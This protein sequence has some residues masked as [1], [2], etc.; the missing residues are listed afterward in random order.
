MAAAVYSVIALHRAQGLSSVAIFLD[1][2]TAFPAT[3]LEL[4]WVLMHKA[5]IT[6]KLWR[7]IR[8]L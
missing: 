2:K 3:F 1:V 8:G 6:G 7:L 5:G 4:L